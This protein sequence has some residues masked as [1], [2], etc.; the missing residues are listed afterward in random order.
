MPEDLSLRVGFKLALCAFLNP[1]RHPRVIGPNYS[2]SCRLDLGDQAVPRVFPHLLRHSIATIVVDSGL[3]P[4]DQVQKFL[5]HVH[6]S[7]TRIYA[8]TSLQV[9]GEQLYPGVGRKAVVGGSAFDGLYFAEILA[10]AR[11]RPIR[12]APLPEASNAHMVGLV[13]YF[14]LGGL[15]GSDSRVCAYCPMQPLLIRSKGECTS[16]SLRAVTWR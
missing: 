14:A 13:G 8:E 16:A 6:L 1:C 2:L 3:V 7:T 9:L 12:G 5:G 15:A 10:F 11:S 4:I